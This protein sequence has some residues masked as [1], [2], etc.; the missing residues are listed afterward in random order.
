MARHN[1]G[2][3]VPEGISESTE[4]WTTP[5]GMELTVHFPAERESG[6]QEVIVGASHEDVGL[7]HWYRYDTYAEFHTDWALDEIEEEN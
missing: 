6:D 1:L 5:Y 3:R 7:V 4:E 2:I